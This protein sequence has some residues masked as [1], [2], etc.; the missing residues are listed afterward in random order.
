MDEYHRTLGLSR[1]KFESMLEHF[2][3][4]TYEGTTYRHIPDYR[5]NLERGTI[6]MRGEVVRGFPKV[7]RTLMIDS[8]VPRY[9]DGRLAV[10]EK[11]NGYN[12]RVAQV[13]GEVLAFSRSGIVCPFTTYEAKRRLPVADFFEDNPELML[14]GEMIGPENPYT[15]H[16]YP[17]VDS[18]AFRAF[19]VREQESGDPLPVERRREL[20]ERYDVPQ[21][22]LFGIFEP[23][24][25]VEALPSIVRK[26]EAEHREGVVMKAIKGRQQLKYTTAA[27]NRG[28]LEYGF[29][30]P[31]DYG[32]EFMFRRLLREGFQAVE[33]DDEADERE[34]ARKLGEAILLPMVET[35]EQI[36]QGQRVGEQHTVRSDP[37]VVDELLEHFRNQGLQ[38]R[39]DEDYREDGERVVEFRKDVQS[40]NDKI[41][42]Y[43][44]GMVVRE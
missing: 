29:R 9:F 16:D 33:L 5:S 40:T 19:D 35:I 14:C 12:T 20:C 6:L 8:G 30:F 7:P 18:I 38:L 3:E 11:L 28:D 36:D 39:I 44:D 21:T 24:D 25:A 15:A 13:D 22:Q 4:S 41:Q 31:F 37:D 2:E 32:R 17:E 1:S 23:D 27:A 26:L 10:E 42:N 34:R 43:L